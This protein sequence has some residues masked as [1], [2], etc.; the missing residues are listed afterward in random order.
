LE[1]NKR[2]LGFRM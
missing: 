2:K 1:D